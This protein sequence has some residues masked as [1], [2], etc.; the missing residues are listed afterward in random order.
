MLYSFNVSDFQAPT[1]PLK[2]QEARSNDNTS[3]PTEMPVENIKL[4]KQ[5][6]EMSSSMPLKSLPN[7]PKMVRIYF[8]E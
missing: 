6:T 3:K 4:K 8:L 1:F 5:R 2:E 7:R